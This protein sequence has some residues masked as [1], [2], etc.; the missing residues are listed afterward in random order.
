MG[1]RDSAAKRNHRH[2]RRA[3]LR[4]GLAIGGVATSSGLAA[5][6]TKGTSRSQPSTPGATAGGAGT[7]RPGGTLNL[8]Q[9]NNP[10]TLDPQRSTGASTMSPVG[11]VM[12]RPFRFKLGAD[13]Q[14]AENHDLENDLAVRAESPDAIT[15]TIKLRPDAQFQNVAPVNGRRV[16]AEDIKATFTRALSLPQNPSRGA[17]SMID[18]GQIETPAPDTVVFK[19]SYP[20]APFS[21]T[22]ASQ[23]YSW[24]FPREVATN[25][26]DPGKQL[27]GSG[28]FLLDSYTP[29]VALSFK[30]NPSWFEKGRPYVD[31]VRIA[32]VPDSTQALAQFTAGNLEIVSLIQNNLEAAK[33]NNRQA[34]LITATN[35]SGEILYFQLGNSSSPFRDIRIRRAISMAIDRQTIGRI[36]YGNQYESGFA[37]RLFLG[38]WALN[39]K[40]LP[41][42]TAQYYKFDLSEAKKLFT[43]AG[44]ENLNVRISY[45]T[46]FAGTAE[47]EP[48]TQTLF[49]MLQALPWK[50]SLGS[51]DYT[52]DFIAG[53]KGLD[54]GN[55][56]NDMMLSTGI[57][58]Y[59]EVDEYL[60]NY[61]DSKSTRNQENLADPKLDALID[62]A[63]TILDDE[64]RRKAYLDIQLYLADQMDSVAGMPAG[65][66]YVFVQPWLQNYQYTFEDGNFGEMW[67]SLWLNK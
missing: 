54:Y 10:T 40:Q 42:D 24:I 49:N 56:P 14:V 50:I 5:C 15:W 6:N 38:K 51:I 61:F 58:F 13:P 28:P 67:S 41:S 36:H 19:L 21:K 3:M 25:G 33:Q 32:I 20:Y 43:A 57:T 60:F 64:Q 66:N 18:P 48:V 4:T 23:N 9:A 22:L 1:A 26:Y 46:G 59:T 17:L 27:I 37:V 8:A 53:G 34:R 45:I 62:K 44:G 31:A 39:L 63:R 30:K 16:E 29:D 12:S 65:N 52:K 47:Q 11:A 7:P 2:T 35:G 55:L